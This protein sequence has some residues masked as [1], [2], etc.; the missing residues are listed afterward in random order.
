MKKRLSLFFLILLLSLTFISAQDDTL[1]EFLGRDAIGG[2]ADGED[3]VDKIEDLQDKLIQKRSGQDYDYL[4]QGW[5]KILKKNKYFAPLIR[6]YEQMHPYLSPVFKYT[7]GMDLSISWIFLLALI[8]WITILVYLYGILELFSIFSS[9]TSGVISLCL[10]V[11]IG[12]FFKWP[13][14]FAE[15]LI[16][17]ITGSDNL[18]VQIGLVILVIII[19]VI[20][21]V[22]SKQ[23]GEYVKTLKDRRAQQQEIIDRAKLKSA[24]KNAEDYSKSLNEALGEE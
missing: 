18:W 9:T 20:L 4:R 11:I 16:G 12:A 10:S 21:V 1:P 8:I 17:L 5:S 3:P 2:F 7:M 24:R 14:L 22:Y 23:L 15:F 13:K 6:L 19:L